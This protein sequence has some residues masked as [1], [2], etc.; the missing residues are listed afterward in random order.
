[1]ANLS[2]ALQKTA[3]KK[4]RQAIKYL[5]DARKWPE[6]LGSGSPYNPD[7]RLHDFIAAFCQ[8]K[9]GKMHEAEKLYNNIASYSLDKEHWMGG[10]NPI[11]NYI[12][13][14]VL[15]KEGKQLELKEL[16]GGWKTEQDSIRNWNITP[17]ASGT[18]YEWVLARYNNNTES[19]EKFRKE[20][21]SPAMVNRFKI[22]MKALEIC[23]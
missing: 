2:L 17:D 11:D 20:L 8:M 23:K 4:Y 14:L 22:L 6:N 7:T 13:M 3:Q 21:A 19:A 15:D 9:L 12:S 16:M 1:L 10:K 5:N 18:R